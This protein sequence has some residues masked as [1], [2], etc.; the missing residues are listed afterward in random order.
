MTPEEIAQEYDDRAGF[1]LVDYMEVG[2]PV[3]RLVSIVLTL[4]PKAYSPI[5]EF[6]LR[7]V[8]AGLAD[9]ADIAGFLGIADTVVEGAASSLY[10]GDE[11]NVLQ[12]GSLA[13][14][15]KSKEILSHE[16]LIVPRDQSL[17]FFYDGLTKRPIG[18]DEYR[19]VPPKYLR[20]RGQREIRAFPAKR[21]KPDDIDPHALRQAFSNRSRG[22][23][24]SVQLLQVKSIER[25]FM[26]FIPA[27]ALIY[28][29]ANNNSVQ[30]G[31][32]IDGRLSVEHEAAFAACGGPKRLGIEEAI[33]KPKSERDV[34][35]LK[36]PIGPRSAPQK[37][38]DLHR[39]KAID[40]F[41]S[42]ASQDSSTQISNDDVQ[43][44][45]VYEHPPLLADALETSKD[46]LI[47]ISP[48]ITEA[49][50]DREFIRKLR[51][52]LANGVNVFIG[53]GLGN[54]ERPNRAI[55]ELRSIARSNEQ[56]T[57]THLGDTHAK[58]LIKDGDWLV[59]SSFNWLSFKGDPRR[60]FREEWGTWVAIPQEVE[61][62]AQR[63]LARLSNP[64]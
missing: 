8:E 57:F 19:T 39:G 29:A 4:Q 27:T 30:V 49:V 60:T 38:A 41:I 31:F 5:E 2:L 42:R 43:L 26:N 1:S 33:L 40:G 59:T 54:D 20:D 64:K 24:P 50:V 6:V 58:I 21:P 34:S 25:A 15:P 44:V 36:L 63:F 10:Q 28:R 11:L 35:G 12:D 53:Y 18:F 17:V 9:P 61:K 51:S 62:A 46:R 14:T 45:S 52:L 7:S 32:A 23:E 13:L 37:S 56:L 16:R 55:N 48:W 3:F 22:S 47:I